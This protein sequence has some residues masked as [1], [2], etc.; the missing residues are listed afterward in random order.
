MSDIRS[1]KLELSKGSN[2][3][4]ACYLNDTR[5]VGEKCWG[6]ISEIHSFDLYE[7][8]LDKLITLATQLKTTIEK[9]REKWLKKLNKKL[10]AKDF[11][12][13]ENCA[14][15]WLFNSGKTPSEA[16]DEIMKNIIKE[17]GDVFIFHEEDDEG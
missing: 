3:G 4:T 8:D 2:A 17:D 6:F 16:F 7:N 15:R 13:N 12:L 11:E 10:A 14:A 5:V 9:N 1:V